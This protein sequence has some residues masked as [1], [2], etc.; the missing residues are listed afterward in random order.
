[1]E[2]EPV[3]GTDAAFVLTDQ[4]ADFDGEAHRGQ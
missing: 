3:D 4:L 2:V 1:L